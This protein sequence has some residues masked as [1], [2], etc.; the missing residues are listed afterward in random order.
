MSVRVVGVK[1]VEE[2]LVERHYLP[3]VR[4]SRITRELEVPVKVFDLQIAVPK[5]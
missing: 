5:A 2:G 3:R 1:G 4:S